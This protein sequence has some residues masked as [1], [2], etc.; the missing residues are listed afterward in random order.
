[1][2]IEKFTTRGLILNHYL[3]N[4]HDVALKVYT[5][6]FGVIMILAKSLRKKESKLK[7]HVRKY[8]YANLTLVKGREIYRLTGAVEILHKKVTDYI[9]AKDALI[10]KQ[11]L[12]AEVC[13]LIERLYGGEIKQSSLFNKIFNYISQYHKDTSYDSDSLDNVENPETKKVN[14]DYSVYRIAIYSIIL[15]ELGYMDAN[16]LGIKNI[17]EYKTMNINDLL[18]N[19][20][21]Y[22]NNINR[23]LHKAI[24]ESML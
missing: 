9:K 7:A 17:N 1:M 20:S 8:H 19:V 23:E 10:N 14:I 18:L 21:L 11:N 22:K 6:D 15:I 12:V 13:K 2:A 4:E 5:E 3:N 16:V 24:R